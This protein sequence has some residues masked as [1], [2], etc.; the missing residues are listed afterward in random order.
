MGGKEGSAGGELPERLRKATA[1]EMLE[2]APGRFAP[3]IEQA[4]V[5]EYTLAR[6]RRNPDGMYTAVPFTERLVR[7]DSGLARLLGFGGDWNTLRRLGRAG[8]IE[9]IVVTPGCSLIN[10]DSW[11][12]HL[13]RCAEEPEF[14]DRDGK[15]FREYQK[16]L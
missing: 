2:V 13:R 1:P 11:F 10:L 6:W 3:R 16:A 9:L 7:M 12:N 14:W 4:D 8:F 15:N 5:S